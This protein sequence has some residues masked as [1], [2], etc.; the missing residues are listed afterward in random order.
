MKSAFIQSV[1]LILVAVLSKTMRTITM[2]SAHLVAPNS[3]A[4]RTQLYS[5][6][7]LTYDIAHILSRGLSCPSPSF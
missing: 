6:R 2:A 1:S 5:D 7:Q 4:Y 3:I